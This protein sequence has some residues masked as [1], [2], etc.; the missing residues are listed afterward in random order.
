MTYR[1]K[2]HD[3]QVSSHALLACAALLACIHH[4]YELAVLSALVLV[5]SV[6]YH[7]RPE[8][9][10]MIADVDRLMA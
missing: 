3:W 5:C 10:G 9:S 8:K 1:R 6:A 4:V 7:R 2:W